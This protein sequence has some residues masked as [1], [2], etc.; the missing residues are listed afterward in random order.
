MIFDCFLSQHGPRSKCRPSPHSRISLRA[1]E[2]PI[3][4]RS[5]LINQI[6][7]IILLTGMEKCRLGRRRRAS[8]REYVFIHS[9]WAG[10]RAG[11]VGG[12]V[13]Q[14]Y[15]K[16]DDPPGK[17]PPQD[18]PQGSTE[19]VGRT[20][21]DFRSI[22]RRFWVHPGTILGRFCV[23]TRDVVCVSSA[24]SHA[25]DVECRSHFGSR[26]WAF[27]RM[28]RP[29]IRKYVAYGTFVNMAVGH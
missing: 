20:W 6:I 27:A 17:F 26:S 29:W 3:T 2:L 1:H 18:A 22:F 28:C 8:G 25:S 23:D 15:R 14:A 9:A 11:I 12:L 24:R 7:Q 19:V 10:V 5:R 21:I 4:S 13:Y 16:R